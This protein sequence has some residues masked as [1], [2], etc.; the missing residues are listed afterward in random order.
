M[1]KSPNK[2]VKDV[3]EEPTEGGLKE[4]KEDHTVSLEKDC[5]YRRKTAAGKIFW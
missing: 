4:D 1:P 2:E 3:Q 5:I